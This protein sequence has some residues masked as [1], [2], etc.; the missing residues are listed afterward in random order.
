[1]KIRSLKL[2]LTAALAIPFLMTAALAQSVSTSLANLPDADM[3]IYISPQ[4]VLNDAAPRVMSEKDVVGMRGAFADMKKS[5]GFDPSS[6]DYLVFALRFHKP[7]GDLSFVAPDVMAVIGGDFSAESLFSLAQLTLQS[8]VRVEKYGSKSMAVM[9]VDPI[10]SEAEKMPM[11]KSLVDVG[12]VPLSANSLA[13]GNLP[14][15]KS[16]IDAADGNGRI[17]PALV[18]SLMRD[19][20]V[21]MATAGAPLAS[22][23]KA[24]GMF[25]TETTPREGAC[26]TP[27]GNFYS[28]VT[29][30]GTN[31]SVRGAMNADNPD[32]AKIISSL[33]SMIMQQGMNAGADK[34]AQNV[35]DS[36]KLMSAESQMFQTIMK[37]IKLMPKDNEVVWEADI[38]QQAIADALKPKPPKAEAKTTAPAPRK[39][40]RKKRTR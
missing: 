30:N 8:R 12:A 35:L 37:S 14:Y 23:A 17:N 31:F 2:W 10:A 20:N 13:I 24:F 4:R 38:P 3:L 7:A 28:A 21:L 6:V 32:T 33:I 15:L 9:R 36:M 39:P 22:F 29:I 11:L 18:D 27:F 34:Q 26:N 19:P 5:L 1:M 40:V 25:G 16:A